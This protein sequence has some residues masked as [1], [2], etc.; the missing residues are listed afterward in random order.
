LL[1]L[2]SFDWGISS[3]S[4]PGARF[5]CWATIPF[6]FCYWSGKLF[7]IR[8]KVSTLSKNDP[9]VDF[10]EFD[11]ANPIATREQIDQINPH[12]F[13]MALVDGILFEEATTCRIAGYHDVLPDEFWARGHMPNMPLMPGV[14]MCECAAQLSSYYAIKNKIVGDG[15]IGLGGL[16]DVKCRGMVVPGDRLVVMIQATK[17]RKGA[18]FLCDFQGFVDQKLVV[19]GIIKGV[20][21]QNAT[22]PSED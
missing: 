17:I 12:R 11:M 8:F 9:I 2:C 7:L 4:N 14:L 3:T 6:I 10:S 15:I 5:I 18:M 1:K 13:E 19:S 20:P 21:L 16:D 22:S